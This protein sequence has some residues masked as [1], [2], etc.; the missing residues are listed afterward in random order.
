MYIDRE[1]TDNR[2]RERRCKDVIIMCVCVELLKI[3]AHCQC[4][5]TDTEETADEVEKEEEEGRR[6]WWTILLLCRL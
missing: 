2:E 3:L 4:R 1:E 5:R 6:W